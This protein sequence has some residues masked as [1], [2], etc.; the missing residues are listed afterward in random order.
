M[1][2]RPPPLTVEETHVNAKK[3]VVEQDGKYFAV[4]E[5]TAI[6]RCLRKSKSEVNPRRASSSRRLISLDIV[7]SSEQC[8]TPIIESYAGWDSRANHVTRKAQPLRAPRC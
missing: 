6:G 5:E 8:G 1:T 4:I 3:S 2:I 7:E